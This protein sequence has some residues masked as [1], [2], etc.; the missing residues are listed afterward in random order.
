MPG[1]SFL[2]ILLLSDLTVEIP[3]NKYIKNKIY[4]K[5]LKIY[6]CLIFNHVSKNLDLIL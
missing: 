1:T 4:R 6:F 2:L 5:F 3:A